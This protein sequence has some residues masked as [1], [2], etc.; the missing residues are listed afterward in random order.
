[1]EDTGD[2]EA[3]DDDTVVS[4]S[5]SSSAVSADADIILSFV[6]SHGVDVVGV[7]IVIIFLIFLCCCNVL[8]IAMNRP[9]EKDQCLGLELSILRKIRL[10]FNT[11]SPIIP[12]S[13]VLLEEAGGGLGS[14]FMWVYVLT[15]EVG[16]QVA[17][18][19]ESS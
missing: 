4:V 15:S 7:G 8:A 14:S 12:L 6:D 17:Q 13:C 18:S 16:W 11:A 1:M 9:Q 3:I 2:T 5:L 10:F 19:K